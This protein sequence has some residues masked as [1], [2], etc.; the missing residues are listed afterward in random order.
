M[1]N[2]QVGDIVARKSYGVDIA[3]VITEIEKSRRREREYVLKGLEYRLV[4]DANHDDLV[5][6]NSRLT[7]VNKQ[8]HLTVL[9]RQ[10]FMKQIINSPFSLIRLTR[11]PG[12]ILHIDASQQFLNDSMRYYRSMGLRPVGV[13]VDEPDQPQKVVG[14]LRQYHPDIVVLTGHDGIRKDSTDLNSYESYKNSIYYINA[15]KEARRYEPNPEKLFIFAGA[16]QS[17][18]EAIMSAG[19]NFASSP[20]RVLVHSFDPVIVSNRI[21]TTAS[22][23]IVTPREAIAGTISGAKG[24]GGINTRGR[25]TFV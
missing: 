18:Y 9:L 14:L 10:T 17:Y 20:G 12:S 5:K 11:R 16:C 15:V 22:S 6:L 3:F 1:S 24:I 25:M 7:N 8:K 4:A 19:A 13:F 23:Q 21:A 2:Y